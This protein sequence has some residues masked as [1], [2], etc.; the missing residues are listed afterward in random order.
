MLESL[1]A[2]TPVLISDQ[3]PWLPS[4]E[5]AVQI[6]PLGDPLLWASSIDRW[7]LLDHDKRVRLRDD[8]ARYVNHYLD[9]SGVIGKTRSLFVNAL[10]GSLL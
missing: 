1:A 6:L 10:S 2:G 3:T 4:S 9:Q 8:A 7:A 5:G